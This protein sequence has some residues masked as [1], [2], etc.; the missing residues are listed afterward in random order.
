MQLDKSY[1]KVEMIFDHVKHFGNAYR[2]HLVPLDFQHELLGVQFDWFPEQTVKEIFVATARLLYDGVDYSTL[3]NGTEFFVREGTANVGKGKVLI[4]SD[5]DFADY[6]MFLGYLQDKFSGN[7][8]SA[9]DKLHSFIESISKDKNAQLNFCVYLCKLLDILQFRHIGYHSITC[10]HWFN[11]PIKDLLFNCFSP[12]V[13]EQACDFDYLKWYCLYARKLKGHES[14]NEI[15][16]LCKQLLEQCNYK[17]KALVSFYVQTQIS[18]LDYAIHELP[19]V[20][21]GDDDA[22]K[23]LEL[24]N[25][26]RKILKIGYGTDEHFSDRLSNIE[27]EIKGY[28]KTKKKNSAF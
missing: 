23:D 1:I 3:I 16:I 27:K 21:L 26:L 11:E 19:G 15:Y 22:N 20:Y 24:V 10:R 28:V 12:L 5:F 25:E 9:V 18:D 17:D 4:V 7:R 2:P 6:P 14:Y 13:K 8:K